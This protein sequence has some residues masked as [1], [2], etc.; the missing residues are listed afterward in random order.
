MF[1]LLPR[2]VMWIFK[3]KEKHISAQNHGSNNQREQSPGYKDGFD[4]W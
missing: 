4:C 1:V 3:I 2:F